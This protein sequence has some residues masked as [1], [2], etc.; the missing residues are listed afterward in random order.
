M[1][2]R[3]RSRI[4]LSEATCPCGCGRQ[5]NPGWLDATNL[6]LEL[7]GFPVGIS[8]MARCYTYNRKIKG[9]SRS[10]HKLI[11]EDYGATDGKQ[12]NP[13]KR[14]KMLEAAFALWHLGL[15]N[16]MEVCDGHIHIAKVSP[17]HPYC[18]LIHWGK[19]K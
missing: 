6:W 19:S 15:I 17:T 9:S 5:P 14:A 16:H 12:R 18:G 3:I 11:K 8:N 4:L 13:R 1:K 10:P 2:E 7:C